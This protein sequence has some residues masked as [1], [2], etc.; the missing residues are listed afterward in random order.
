MQLKWEPSLGQLSWPTGSVAQLFSGD[1]PDGLRG[2]EYHF[3][4]ADELAKWRRP[5]E[6]WNN[7][8][9]GLRAG[10]RPRALVTTT[11]RPMQLLE[12]ISA[13]SGR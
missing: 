8:Q 2:P 13:S 11:P 4:W 7:L 1:N 6:A 10:P 5:E 9:M 12:R 3:A